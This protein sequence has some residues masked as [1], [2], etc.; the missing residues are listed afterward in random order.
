[1]QILA[2]P[3]PEPKFAKNILAKRTALQDG[4]QVRQPKQK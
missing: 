2:N 1:M 3:S 4:G